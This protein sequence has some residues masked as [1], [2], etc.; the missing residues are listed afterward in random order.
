MRNAREKNNRHLL[1]K[2]NLVPPSH[3]SRVQLTELLRQRLGRTHSASSSKLYRG[4]YTQCDSMADAALVL[5]KSLYFCR[6][7]TVSL[8]CTTTS[9]VCNAW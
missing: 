3:S 5:H 8:P 9:L 2:P 6:N 1:V 4:P 7:T